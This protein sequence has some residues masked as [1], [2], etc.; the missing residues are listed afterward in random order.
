MNLRDYLIRKKI[1]IS[2]FGR[3]LNYSRAHLSKIVNGKQRPSKKLAKSI[4][5]AT[6]GEVK[7]WSL[8]KNLEVEDQSTPI[9][10]FEYLRK[11]KLSV[12]DFG[13]ILNYSRAHLSKIIHGRQ[14]PSKKLA[15]AIE[16]V[17]D[18]RIKAQDL[19]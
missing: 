3:I 9:D 6:H 15:E 8:L 11:Q 19:L 2:D 10:L 7:A 16:K 14:R 12:T 5:K 1:S 18:G 13:E 17:T 4:E